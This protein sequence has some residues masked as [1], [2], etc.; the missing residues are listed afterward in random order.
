[1]IATILR[2]SIRRRGLIVC[3]TLLFVGLGLYNLTQ[4]SVDAVPDVTNRQVQINALAPALGA[5][6]MERRV[7][8]PLELA[9]AGMPRLEEVR[10]LSQFGLS[11][12]T[13][14]F[15]DDTDIYR[16]RQWVAER[17]QQAT[18]SL[19]PGVKTEMA[20]VS[21]G[22]GEILYLRLRNPRLSLME[23]RSLMDWVVRPQLR[24]VAGLADVN[25][26]GGEVRQIQVS[27]DP[28]RL[29]QHEL[30]V[31]DVIRAIQENNANG[32]GAFIEQ[33]SQQQVV[34]VEGMLTRPEDLEK[35]SVTPAQGPPIWLGLLSQVGFGP[36][37]RQGAITQDGAGEEVYAICL[38]L[39]GENG[40]AVVE[41]VKARLP[42]I[43]KSL[44]EGS[45]LEPFL[46]RSRLIAATLR[47]AGQNLLEG[48]ILVVGLLF[49]FLLQ[50]RAGLIV[51][52]AI[53]LAMLF[54]MC[55]M[56]YFGISANLMS[57]GAIDFGIIVDGSVII[58]ENCVR[59]LADERHRLGR[60]LSEA[61]RLEAIASASIEVRQATQFGE[62]L[63][64][65][66]YL[67]ILAL[68]GLEGKMFRPMGWTVI[69]AL[70]GAMICTL[71]VVPALCGYFLKAE[72]EPEHPLIHWLLPRYQRS[73]QFLMNWGK[74]VMLAALA[75]ALLGVW[76]FFRLGTEFI[77]ELA[78][79]AVA[80][81]I[82]Y[83]AG[84]SLKE[85]IRLSTAAEKTVKRLCSG[86]VERVVTRIGR[87]EIA[88]DPMLTCQTDLLIELR[89]GVAQEVVVDRLSEEMSGKPGVDVSFT[90][91]I[92]M[93]MMELIEGVGIR[94]DLGIKLFGDDH[95]ELARQAQ[96]VA[97]LVKTVPGAADVT[98]EMT[99]GL[100][101][102][103]IEVDRARLAQFGVTVADV[104]RIVESAV[105]CRPVSSIND[106][107]Q[108]FE[109]VVRLP[110]NLRND[111]DVI[112]K[113]LISNSRGEHLPLNQLATLSD[114]LGP[115]QISRE[116]GK[117]RIVIQSNVRGRD[118]GSFVEAV[119]ARLDRD[120]K[121][122]VGYYL[123]YAG[124]YE[125]LQSGRARLALVVPL[126]FLMVFGL[127]YWTFASLRLAALVF[128]SIPL[129]I[130]GG[131][132]ALWLR[133]MSLSISAAVGF[134]ALAGVAVLNGVV[135]LTFIEQLRRDGE[136]AHLAVVRGAGLRLRP[137]LMTACVAA[138]GF[139][140]MAISH[141]AGAEVQR[142]L[143]T[144]V[145]GGLFSSSLLTL[146]VLPVLY[147]LSQ[148]REVV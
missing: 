128:T 108:R 113:L 67:P 57:L 39:L 17:L 100:K 116:N 30:A 3:L 42:G 134:V 54:A 61:E 9:L 23:R 142:P 20:P 65:A 89:P 52:S 73:I 36:M 55:G 12:L 10:S 147:R 97:A 130:T 50:L 11:Q 22:L 118:L 99:Q 45:S 95:K 93:R 15:H 81:Q 27:V 47:T 4:L 59:R 14:I 46:D 63:I 133:G 8:F 109:I 49:A 139:L 144:V 32:G 122:P 112:G 7:T 18:D 129:A 86:L 136:P 48:G 56:R 6:E 127:L 1:M 16:A 145:I 114:R 28:E 140:P 31:D 53:P 146:L 111:V 85:S 43:E 101:Q 119:Q 5:E 103:Q 21:T 143:A 82:T 120:L 44:P 84:I 91:P 102:L 64:L 110:D 92:K 35:I 83:P 68:A 141:G 117:R 123:Q 94:A 137:V 34:Q 72:E 75:I 131:V 40:S 78:E 26:W 121:L 25:T 58:V 90:Q 13:V 19:P 24:S 62:I 71:T 51:S 76:L 29:Q 70:G 88:T 77:P 74:S 79:G 33:A 41:A 125:K 96:R 60:A 66:S 126:T 38:L 124:T 107:N 138:F 2:F 69:M 115:V 104:N 105:G 132:T 148:P 98:V 37:I 87:P 106:G 135:M 80:V